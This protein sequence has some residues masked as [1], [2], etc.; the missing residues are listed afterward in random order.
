L[1]FVPARLSN[2][3]RV[4]EAMGATIEEPSSGSHW[5]VRMD[6]MPMYPIPAHNGLR[7][8]ISDGYIKRMCSNFKIDYEEFRRKL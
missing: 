5:K 2:I 6:G 4:L 8:E 7:S 3:K 1:I